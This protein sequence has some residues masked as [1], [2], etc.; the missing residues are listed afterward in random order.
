MNICYDSSSNQLQ[1]RFHK[2]DELIARLLG[3]VDEALLR[4]GGGNFLHDHL[5]NI[6]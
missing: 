6:T 1:S 2:T 3:S 5:R 4:A